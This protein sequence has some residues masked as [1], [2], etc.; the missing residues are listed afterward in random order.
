M[1]NPNQLTALRSPRT[2]SVALAL[3]L[4]KAVAVAAAKMLA[5]AGKPLLLAEQG[6]TPSTDL[7]ATP[8]WH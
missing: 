3:A 2:G 5:L 6:L 8:S 1:Q 7:W 4:L